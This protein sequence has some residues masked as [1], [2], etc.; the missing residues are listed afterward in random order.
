MIRTRFDKSMKINGK[1]NHM[2]DIKIRA[3]AKR[4]KM[5][6]MIFTM[7]NCFQLRKETLLC[8]FKINLTSTRTELIM[9][10]NI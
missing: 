1:E 3:M 8:K 7:A 5:Q 2:I 6:P 10:T 4:P 9:L